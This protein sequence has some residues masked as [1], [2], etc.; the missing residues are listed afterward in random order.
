MYYQPTNDLR[1]EG[2][3]KEISAQVRTYLEKQKLGY[4][5]GVFFLGWIRYY[6]AKTKKFSE[7]HIRQQAI[8]QAIVQMYVRN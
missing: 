6:A 2:S 5:S 1:F 4:D 7:K 3:H 8:E